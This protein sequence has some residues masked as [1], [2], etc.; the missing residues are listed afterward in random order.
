MEIIYLNSAYRNLSFDWMLW[1]ANSGR[2]KAPDTILFLPIR[3][4]ILEKLSEEIY[5][6]SLEILDEIPD[7]FIECE[8]PYATSK[9]DI[10]QN[11]LL[12][13]EYCEQSSLWKDYLIEKLSIIF[14]WETKVYDYFI[15]KFNTGEII[16][17]I[18]HFSQ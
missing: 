5:L 2:A 11:P 17:N 8:E 6:K 12:L 1:D 13:N 4:D 7:Y 18:F 10:L 16:N 15:I 14:C 9:Y 3:D